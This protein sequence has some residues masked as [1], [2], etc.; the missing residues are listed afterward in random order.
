MKDNDSRD[1]IPP[2]EM[3][4]IFSEKYGGGSHG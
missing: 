2:R 3:R 4:H 1:W